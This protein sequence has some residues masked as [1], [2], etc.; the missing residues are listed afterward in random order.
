MTATPERS[1]NG[2]ELGPT[3]DAPA[4]DYRGLCEDVQDAVDSVTQVIRFKE[5]QRPG[6]Q[7][8]RP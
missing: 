2:M 3:P 4:V 6:L 5:R 1:L 7:Q 8:D